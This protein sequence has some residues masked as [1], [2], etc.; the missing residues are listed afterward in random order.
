MVFLGMEMWF[1]VWEHGPGLEEMNLRRG[2][3]PSRAQ[4]GGPGHGKGI[5]G[6]GGD[7]RHGCS[8]LGNSLACGEQELTP[9]LDKQALVGQ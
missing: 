7:P 4:G 3:C 8:E 1:W 6:Q 9:L 2:N 5:L